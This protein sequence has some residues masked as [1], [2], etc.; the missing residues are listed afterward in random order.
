MMLTINKRM[1]GLRK[2]RGL[3]LFRTWVRTTEPIDKIY[4]IDGEEPAAGA[5]GGG[6]GTSYEVTS[7]RTTRPS[8]DKAP[9]S[10]K[11]KET[12]SDTAQ[13]LG[14]A[15]TAADAAAKP[16]RKEFAPAPA[17]AAGADGDADDALAPAPAEE[18]IEVV[19]NGVWERRATLPWV[20]GGSPVQRAFPS[21]LARTATGPAAVE[22]A[23]AEDA[24]PTEEPPPTEDADN[25]ATPC[26]RAWFDPIK[27]LEQRL[28]NKQSVE[29][30]LYDA[31][32]GAGAQEELLLRRA[33]A[34]MRPSDDPRSRGRVGR[35]R[36]GSGTRRECGG[37]RCASRNVR[38]AF[39]CCA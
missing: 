28:E 36:G 34:R 39:S 6:G 31:A 11:R 22:E 5:G 9:A 37:H 20:P 13:Q 14:A 4:D 23:A 26:A 15:P 32:K 30:S 19:C 29:Q 16:P 33:R 10:K 27:T 7:R 35:G 2:K 12:C 25:A 18:E 21:Q 1:T 3:Q 24:A 8:K 17:A 38:L